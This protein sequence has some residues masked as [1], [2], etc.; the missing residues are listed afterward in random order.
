MVSSSIVRED[1]KRHPA[2]RELPY[3]L[4]IVHG[5]QDNMKCNNRVKRAQNTINMVSKPR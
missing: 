2:E 5:S 4:K 3:K 1:R